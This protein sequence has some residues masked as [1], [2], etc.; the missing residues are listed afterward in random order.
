MNDEWHVLR[1]NGRAPNLDIIPTFLLL[2]SAMT[3]I[4]S[5]SLST[6]MFQMLFKESVVKP[7]V[8]KPSLDK[9]LLENYIQNL[10]PSFLSKLF[11]RERPLT[12][13]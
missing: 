6:G 12:S 5:L 2:V 9:E 1:Q 13:R 7:L 10:N 8:K 11:E 3:K 4:I